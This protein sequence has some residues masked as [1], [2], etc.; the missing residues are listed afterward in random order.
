[1]LSQI[2]STPGVLA[3]PRHG[4]QVHQVHAGIGGRFDPDGARGGAERAFYR[5]EVAQVH[6]LDG[7][8]PVRHDAREQAVRPAVQVVVHD[9]V[10]ARSE[11]HDERRFGGHAGGED[12]A[13][14]AVFERGNAV[15]ERSPRRVA[16]AGIVVRVRL[17]DAFEGE[18]GRLVDG[19]HHRP[20]GGVGRLSGVDGKRLESVFRGHRNLSIAGLRPSPQM[21]RMA[22][23]VRVVLVHWKAEEAEGRIAALQAGGFEVS[24]GPSPTSSEWKTIVALPPEAFVIDLD[25]LPSHG[26]AVA[27]LLRQRKSTRLVPI[28]FAG[29]L[30]DKVEKARELLP[31][32]HFAAW[33][34]IV[35]VLKKAIR[36]GVVAPVVP[37]GLGYKPS[38]LGKRIGLREGSIVSLLGAPSRFE[39]KLE[40]LPEGA[41]VRTGRAEAP[42]IVLVFAPSSLELARRFDPA[43]GTLAPG[44][45]LWVLWPKRASGVETDLTMP[46]IREFALEAGWVDYK[47]CSVD[48]TWSAMLFGRQRK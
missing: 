46:F 12:E 14:A 34:R 23:M 29:G 25:R 28:V 11:H 21:R 32:A 19:R 7:D 47:V 44:G 1:V 33:P 45:K 17:V 13:E 30:P 31:D 20:E 27:N 9:Q 18:R 2:V 48:E 42:G 24:L 43:V 39:R 10:V 35:T 38:P 36:T 16:A 4:L 22:P 37:E 41:V 26:R 5:F 6:V 8:A 40:P 3:D 15:F